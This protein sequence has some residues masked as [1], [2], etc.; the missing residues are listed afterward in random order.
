MT[1][2]NAQHIDLAPLAPN[3]RQDEFD[4]YRVEV[5]VRD[6]ADGGEPKLVYIGDLPPDADDDQ[7]AEQWGDGIFSL[8]PMRGATKLLPVQHRIARGLE[9][10]WRRQVIDAISA[11]NIDSDRDGQAPPAQ[12]GPMNNWSGGGGPMHGFGMGMGPQP[13]MPGQPGVAGQQPGMPMHGAMM[14]GMMPGF[15]MGQQQQPPVPVQ[16]G[17]TQFPVSPG[18]P[19]AEQQ[20]MINRIWQEQQAAS[21]QS[22]MFNM[23]NQMLQNVMQANASAGQNNGQG[24][25]QTVQY[26]Q[27]QLQL[28]QGEYE[29]MSQRLNSEI[30]RLTREVQSLRDQNRR[31][32]SA[33]Q[34]EYEKLYRAH[35]DMQKQNMELAAAIAARAPVGDKDAMAKFA[36][37]LE[38]SLPHAMP[39]INVMLAKAMGIPLEQL[40]GG[41]APQPEG[42]D[43][44]GGAGGYMP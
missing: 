8:I 3:L 25:N 30:D 40:G 7:I 23:M 4:H 28:K 9:P 11:H 22:M 12:R 43:P 19:P 5:E 16:V 13:G 33:H 6:S 20:A 15:G 1:Q 17:N 44:N 14:P 24:S 39:I 10:V 26:L 35:L 21:Q 32:A 2:N 18:L 38:K 29:M 41:G 27:Q 36:G 31:D 42:G 37:A 34:T